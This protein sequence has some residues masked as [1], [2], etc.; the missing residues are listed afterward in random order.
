MQLIKWSYDNDPSLLV[1]TEIQMSWE[2]HLENKACHL[3]HSSQQEYH[4]STAECTIDYHDPW[5]M[6]FPCL[7]LTIK[8]KNLMSIIANTYNTCDI[9]QGCNTPCS[10]VVNCLATRAVS[11]TL[12]GI[13]TLYNVNVISH[14]WTRLRTYIDH[15]LNGETTTYFF[16]FP[17]T[18]M[19]HNY[20][21]CK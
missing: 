21:E 7:H 2:L 15:W 18:L 1:A 9:P 4:R 17:P 11:L 8:H 14:L 3:A 19:K 13:Y 6:A 16:I 5:Q 10:E 20:L 12:Q